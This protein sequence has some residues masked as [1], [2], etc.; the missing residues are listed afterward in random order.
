MNFNLLDNYIADMDN[1]DLKL[2]LFT[3][4]QLFDTYGEIVY[5]KVLD[6]IP[7]MT[8]IGDLPQYKG[9]KKNVN[10]VYED[11]QTPTNSFT[12]TPKTGKTNIDVQGTSSQYYPRKNYKL[13][14]DKGTL[15]KFSRRDS[16]R[17]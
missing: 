11:L 10:I 9:N 3:R 4:N 16:C 6:Q 15:K 5:S 13:S 8:I 17:Q 12:V 2:D 14:F 7:C 1:V